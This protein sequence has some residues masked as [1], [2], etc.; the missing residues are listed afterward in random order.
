[1][2]N[3]ANVVRYRSGHNGAVLKTVDGDE[4]SVGSNPTRTASQTGTEIAAVGYS[5]IQISPL[6]KM[7][8]DTTET[9][10]RY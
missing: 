9:A 4:S 1:M 2:P 10:G 6:K 7:L 3:S 8:A 5:G